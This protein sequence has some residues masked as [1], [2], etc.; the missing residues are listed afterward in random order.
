MKQEQG[1]AMGQ[2]RG[3]GDGV[4]GMGDLVRWCKRQGNGA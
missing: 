1:W 3:Q 4:T 2:E